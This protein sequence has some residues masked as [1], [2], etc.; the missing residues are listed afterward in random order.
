MS[1]VLLYNASETTTPLVIAAVIEALWPVV[2]HRT[3]AAEGHPKQ[4]NSQD[5]SRGCLG[6]HPRL[7]G[8]NILPFEEVHHGFCSVLKNPPV[9]TTLRSDI[10]QQSFTKNV[11]TID[12]NRNHHGMTEMLTLSNKSH[13]IATS[14][15]LLAP[16]TRSFWL[17]TGVAAVNFFSHQ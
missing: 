5:L 1:T 11:F 6:P 15:F 8:W 4:R 17:F 12:A 16:N 2:V 13:G 10:R 9:S 7:D 14:A 3:P